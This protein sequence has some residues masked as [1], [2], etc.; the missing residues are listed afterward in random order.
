M[1][2][3]RNGR[4]AR[5]KIVSRKGWR[6]ESSLRHNVKKVL[7]IVG[8]TASGKTSLS[9]QLAKKLHGEVI[10][11][12]SRQV[13][14]GLDIGTGKV[15]SKEMK[16]VPHHLLDVAHPKKVF[17]VSDYKTLASKAIDEIIKKGKTPV[18]V[19][20]T[21]FYIDALTG[22]TS[23]P[24]VAPN[25]K[26]RTQ[27]E[28]KSPEVLYAALKKKDPRRAKMLDP[29]N[30]VRVVRALEIIHALGKVPKL[31]PRKSKQFLYIGLQL[32]QETLDKKIKKRLNERIQAGMIQEARKLH[33][34]GL[35]YKRMYSLGLEYRFLA[36]YLQKKISKSELIERIYK[37]N[38]N[39]AKR[40][41]TWFKGNKDIHW[42]TPPLSST[43][44]STI[45]RLL[46]E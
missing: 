5:L 39:Y 44:L 42:F 15:T 17:S 9:I 11:A 23:L 35:S 37:E 3:W 22:T 41:M 10:S 14:K 21:G 46:E 28:K 30:K 32:D 18:V 43:D 13:Y 4:R 16:G 36:E 26:L 25:P 6:F 29:R 31:T 12:D 20:G 27:L 19:G 1:P 7:I 24:E 33:A 38:R 8:P 45:Q 34:S 40:Q 2:E